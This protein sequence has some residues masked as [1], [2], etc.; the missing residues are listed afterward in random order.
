MPSKEFGP[1]TTY[2]AFLAALKAR[3][4]R[5]R[6]SA[7]RAVNR[8]LIDLYWDIG[9]AIK[10]KQSS[11][12]WGEAVVENLARDLLEAYPGNTGFSA[13]NLWRMRQ[14]TDVYTAP[15]FLAQLVRDVP[16]G[17]AAVVSCSPEALA[18]AVRDLVVDVQAYERTRP[19]ASR[20]TFRRRCPSIWPS[21]PKRR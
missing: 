19:E 17:A 16:K 20:T 18:Q 8:E 6:L 4:A 21:R 7:A 9:L 14:A 3:I 15:D 5:A 11:H 10:E 1:D 2:V 13:S 12:G